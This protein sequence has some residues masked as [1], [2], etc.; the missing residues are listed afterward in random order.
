MAWWAK[1]D[2]DLTYFQKW[3]CL[4]AHWCCI[5]NRFFLGLPGAE[6]VLSHPLL[7][8][9]TGVL[10][11]DWTGDEA[12]LTALLHQTPNP[13]V[14]VVLLHEEQTTRHQQPILNQHIPAVQR[15]HMNTTPFTWQ[16]MPLHINATVSVDLSFFAFKSNYKY[17]ITV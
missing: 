12:H 13:P 8:Q 16:P 5:C 9:Q 10:Q 2:S 15:H 6:S 4:W 11:F 17:N 7:L 1:R 14:I 3:A